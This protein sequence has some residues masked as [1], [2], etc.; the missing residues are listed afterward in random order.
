MFNVKCAKAVG[1]FM[2]SSSVVGNI[3]NSKKLLEDGVF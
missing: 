1:S 3:T 2:S